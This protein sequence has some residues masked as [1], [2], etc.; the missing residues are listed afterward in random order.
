MNYHHFRLTFLCFCLFAGINA[1]AYDAEID[2][3]YYNFSGDKSEVTY[4]NT[5]YNSYTYEVVIP[6]SVTYNGRPYHVTTIGQSAFSDCSSL[7][8]I[9]IPNSVTS[10]GIYAFRSCI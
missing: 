5:N 10:I 9:T 1:L 8:S 7:T 4:K 6:E 2:G 3:I